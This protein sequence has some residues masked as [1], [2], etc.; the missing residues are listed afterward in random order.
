[1]KY[2]IKYNEFK[3]D[4]FPHISKSDHSDQKF[5]FSSFEA[6]WFNK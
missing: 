4:S 3:V 5:N 6:S 2:E 1:M